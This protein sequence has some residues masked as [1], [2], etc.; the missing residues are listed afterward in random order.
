MENYLG[1]II[2]TV[3]S[4]IAGLII[5]E[6]RGRAVLGF[7]FG[8]FLGIIG[9]LVIA[10]INPIQTLENPEKDDA[11]K[12]VFNFS[13]D[14]S[15]ILF[16]KNEDTTMLLNDG[17]AKILIRINDFELI[18]SQNTVEYYLNCDIT[19]ITKKDII[20]NEIKV[21]EGINQLTI[22]EFTDISNQKNEGFNKENVELINKLKTI[23]GQYIPIDS[24]IN[25][26]IKITSNII[27]QIGII[28]QIV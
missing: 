4:A 14:L 27:P 17:K 22:S 28:A 5:G 2:Y 12:D 10:A 23:T 11:K 13:C 8:F 6:K 16:A 24:T 20:I 1:I 21:L 3:V 26:K 7:F 25:G 15:K 9:V 19:N 18:V